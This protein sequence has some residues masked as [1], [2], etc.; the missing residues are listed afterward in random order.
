MGERL[1][2][3]G[4]GSFSGESGLVKYLAF[5]LHKIFFSEFL[6]FLCV[7]LFRIELFFHVTSVHSSHFPLYY[8]TFPTR[9]G[10]ID[11]LFSSNNNSTTKVS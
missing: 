5:F 1:I 7:Q 11:S 10:S 9:P 2:S 3:G 8:E 6:L 4:S